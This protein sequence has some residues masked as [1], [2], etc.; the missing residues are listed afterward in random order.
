MDE[1]MENKVKSNFRKRL[2][3]GYTLLAI[4]TDGLHMANSAGEIIK[5]LKP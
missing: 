1:R 2:K 4:G 3:Q 5:T